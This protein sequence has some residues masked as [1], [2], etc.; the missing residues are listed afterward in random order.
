MKNE[1]AACGALLKYLF[2]T[3]CNE[4]LTFPIPKKVAF[5]DYLI[6]DSATS[7]SLEIAYS[8]NGVLS[9]SF[10]GA[11]DKASTPFGARASLHALL[12]G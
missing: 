9:Y 1:L 8:V 11:I 7:K 6:I 4:I 5:S 10:L 12:F 3:Q 2:I